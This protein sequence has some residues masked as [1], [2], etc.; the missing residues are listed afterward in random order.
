[1]LADRTVNVDLPTRAPEDL[2]QPMTQHVEM[3]EGSRR[4]TRT[5]SSLLPSKKPH[6]VAWRFVHE[7]R[8]INLSAA[9]RWTQINAGVFKVSRRPQSHAVGERIPGHTRRNR[10]SAHSG[11]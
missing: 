9:R 2:S 5:A 6:S 7:R 11:P 4:R 10:K 3:H 1:M 8:S